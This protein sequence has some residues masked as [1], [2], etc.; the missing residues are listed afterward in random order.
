M[1]DRNIKPTHKLIKTY[2]AEL[3]KYAQ[4]GEEN[5]GSVRTVSQNLLQYY[6][7]P[8]DLTRLCEKRHA[9]PTDTEDSARSIPHRGISCGLGAFQGCV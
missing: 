5:E 6:C 3:E 8:S 9:L 4:L 1:S 7:H 2:Y